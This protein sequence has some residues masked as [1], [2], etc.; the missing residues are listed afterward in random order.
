MLEWIGQNIP[1]IVAV[2]VLT[3]V[4]ALIIIG[5]IKDKKQG[6]HSC[7]S[8]CSCCPMSD[9]CHSDPKK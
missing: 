4:V 7:G 9:K 3:C 1:T 6:K 2:A 5:M 8:S